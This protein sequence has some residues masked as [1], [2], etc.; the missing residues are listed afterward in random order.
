MAKKICIDAGHYG[1]Y[2]RSPVVPEYYE[3]DMVWKLHMMQKEILESYGFEVILTRSNQATDRGLYDRGYAA[4]GCV[5]FISDHSNACGAESVDYPVVYRGYD[6]IG[7]CDGLALKLAK[8]IASTMGTVQAGRTAT[9]KGSSGGEYYGVLRGARD[10]GLSDYYILEHSFHTN[11]EMTKWLLDDT[12]LR[13]LAEEECRVIAEHYG[14]SKGKAEDKD[15]MTKITGKAKATAEQMEAYIKAKNGSVA[16]SV[17]DMIPLYLSEGEAENIRGDIAFAQSCLETGNFTFSGSA[18]ELSQNNFCGMG[19]TRNGVTGNSFNTPQLGIRAQIQH[20]KAYANTTKLKQDCIDPRFDLVSRGCAP[21]V[22]YLGIQENPK[23]KGWAAGAGYGKKI[24]EI[25]DA[26]LKTGDGHIGDC[27]QASDK[28]QETGFTPYLITTTCEKLN[29]RSGAGTDHN[30]VGVIREAAGKKCKYTIVE[31]KNGW[32]RLKSGAGWINLSY[33]KQVA[34]SGSRT[35][36]T[37]Y[38]VTTICDV[39]NIR[40]GAGAYHSVVGTI[41]EKEGSKN[42]YTI[43][44]EKNGWG[45]LK[46]GAG[47]ISLSYTKRVL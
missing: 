27:G 25:L 6:N 36:F 46:S 15:S 22:E 1:K 9:R 42:G 29:I 43:V 31:E 8:V 24:L 2:N 4:K 30:I 10:A 38:L 14:M 19:V 23:G 21:Y 16:Q 35:D 3:S 44:E 33:T 32:G 28:G 47:W 41:S 12:N 5:L 18:V 34:A 11:A 17:L 7:N 37:P 39:L 13:K 45:R 20:L 26:I 40:S